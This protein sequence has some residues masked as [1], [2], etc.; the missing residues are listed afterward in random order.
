MRAVGIVSISTL[1]A[2][3]VAAQPMVEKRDVEIVT[4]IVNVIKTIDV[5]TTVYVDAATALP[6]S[7]PAYSADTDNHQAKPK[8]HGHQ[9]FHHNPP[10]HRPKYQ[11]PPA[12][13]TT[14]AEPSTPPAYTPSPPP[15]YTPPP[16]PAYTPETT[17]SPVPKPVDNS[18]A[19][20]APVGDVNVGEMTH[21]DPGLGSCGLTNTGDEAIVA[22]A[23]D[24]MNNPANPN[25]N[26]LCGKFITIE[27]EGQRHQA[28]VVDTC[29]ACATGDIDLSL[30]LFQQVAPGGDGRV[31]GVK[32][33][34]NN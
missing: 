24:T 32:W 22:L 2:S 34:F 3:V 16:S 31:A 15:A 9:Q 4:E 26:P 12:S 7:P 1:L 33:W 28:K 14:S 30:T 17:P 19:P 23:V 10:P 13:P 18:P 20:D 25:L 11:S 5:T 21:Y 8:H 29:G 27:F 6:D